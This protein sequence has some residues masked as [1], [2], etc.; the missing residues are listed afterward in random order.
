[1]IGAVR[2]TIDIHHLA[3]DRSLNL[4]LQEAIHMTALRVVKDIQT[5]KKVVAPSQP[6]ILTIAVD[7]VRADWPECMNQETLTAPWK[8]YAE[9]HTRN[10]DDRTVEQTLLSVLN[11]RYNPKH[12]KQMC[13]LYAGLSR[14]V[15]PVRVEPAPAEPVP[16]EPDPPAVD[17]GY[18]RV[19]C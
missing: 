16:V 18:N 3:E 5:S 10:D 13:T 6:E 17:W 14:P 7:V 15:E 8:T 11:S 9:W 1:M 2:E 4:S 19:P 12:L